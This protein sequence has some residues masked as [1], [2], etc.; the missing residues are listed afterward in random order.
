MSFSAEGQ[1]PG[2]CVLLRYEGLEK[3]GQ[4][5]KSCAGVDGPIDRSSRD[6]GKGASVAMAKRSG[7]TI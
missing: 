5:L 6:P 1:S 2:Y 3:S 4:D 7:A